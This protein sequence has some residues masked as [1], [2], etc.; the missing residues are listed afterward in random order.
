MYMY[1]IKLNGFEYLP[2]EVWSYLAGIRKYTDIIIDV[3]IQVHI[4]Q[5][6]SSEQG[7][8]NKS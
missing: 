7:K 3:L 6:T 8:H 5:W 2:L 1:S 4:P